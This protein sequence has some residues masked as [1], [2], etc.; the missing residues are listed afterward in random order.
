MTSQE[1]RSLTIVAN[2]LNVA[3]TP[4]GG[5]IGDVRIRLVPRNGEPLE[6]CDYEEAASFLCDRY[7]RTETSRRVFR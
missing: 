3:A 2:A 6:T 7:G 5:T 4:A 1:L